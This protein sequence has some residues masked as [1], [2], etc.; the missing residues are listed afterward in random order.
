MA[1]VTPWGFAKTALSA[2][3]TKDNTNISLT[4]RIIISLIRQDLVDRVS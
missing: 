2:T 3:Q 1:N 4:L